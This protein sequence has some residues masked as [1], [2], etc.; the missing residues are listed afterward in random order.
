MLTVSKHWREKNPDLIYPLNDANV[1][2][3]L[4]KKNRISL[5]S[6]LSN[7]E[8]TPSSRSAGSDSCDSRPPSLKAYLSKLLT[9]VRKRI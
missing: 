8:I 9:Y 1:K 3:L 2:S 7:C 6:Q 5:W 4:R